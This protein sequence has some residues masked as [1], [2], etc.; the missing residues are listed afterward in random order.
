[1]RKSLVALCQAEVPH[2]NHIGH[3]S[4]AEALSKGTIAYKNTQN[5]L[6]FILP[7]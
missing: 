5:K 4:S 1:M 7:V 6:R 2:Y 3:Q